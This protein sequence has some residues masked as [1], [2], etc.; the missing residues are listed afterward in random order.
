[1]IR[2]GI[3]TREVRRRAG[4]WDTTAATA[5]PLPDEEVVGHLERRDQAVA[6]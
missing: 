2:A 3:A 4:P 1:V 6:D 5:H